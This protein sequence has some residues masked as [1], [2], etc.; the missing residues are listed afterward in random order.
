MTDED[1]LRSE[2]RDDSKAIIEV[3]KDEYFHIMASINI[4]KSDESFNFALPIIDKKN[5]HFYSLILRNQHPLL[6]LIEPP[7]DTLCCLGKWT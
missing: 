7:S 4:R 2:M 5:S 6:I 3:R 1:Y